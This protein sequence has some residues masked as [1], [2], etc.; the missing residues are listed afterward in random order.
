MTTRDT[1]TMENLYVKGATRGEEFVQYERVHKV[2]GFSRTKRRHVIEG[3]C[4]V[5]AA[6]LMPMITVIV[7]LLI[8]VAMYL[9]DVTVVRSLAYG[10]LLEGRQLIE[11]DVIP[12]TDDVMYER[13]LR[14]GIFSRILKDTYKEDTGIM[15]SYFGKQLVGR[16]WVSEFRNAD[17]DVTEEGIRV[18]VSVVAAGPF[19]ELS[20]WIPGDFFRDEIVIEE[21][22]NDVSEKTRIY[23]AVVRTGLRIKGADAVISGLRK[24]L[25]GEED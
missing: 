25:E 22:C 6:F 3:S 14:E 10:V 16:L 13:V 20:E 11:G 2:N 12:G 8:M 17:V 7:F 15:K 5:E 4:T 21:A 18:T 9:R 24:L 19:T 1:H 23:T